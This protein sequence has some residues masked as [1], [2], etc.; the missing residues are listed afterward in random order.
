MF[1][2]CEK[3]QV[4]LLQSVVLIF[5]H[6]GNLEVSMLNQPILSNVTIAF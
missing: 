2:V 3:N 1:E 5:A 4:G 6:K